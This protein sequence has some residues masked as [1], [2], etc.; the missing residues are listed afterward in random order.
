MI[1]TAGAMTIVAVGCY[2]PIELSNIFNYS[3]P[4]LS[5]RLSDHDLSDEI[6]RK[7]LKNLL[8]LIRTTDSMHYPYRHDIAH[9][10]LNDLFSYCVQR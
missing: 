3:V 9:I 1:A 5:V 4:S 8:I 7:N 2:E 10:V 6:Q